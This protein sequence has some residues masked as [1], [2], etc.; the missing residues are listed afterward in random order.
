MGA[1]EK[2]SSA[3]FLPA[4]MANYAIQNGANLSRAVIVK[5]KH[6]D[7]EDLERVLKAEVAKHEAL[8]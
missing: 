6:N 4:Q 5:F 8:K 1:V 7:M 2:P 3:R